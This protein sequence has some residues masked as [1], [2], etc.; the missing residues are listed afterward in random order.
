MIWPDG[1]KEEEDDLSWLGTLNLIAGSLSPQL[2]CLRITR[3][4]TQEEAYAVAISAPLYPLAYLTKITRIVLREHGPLLGT[5][6]RLLPPPSIAA[7]LLETDHSTQ[8]LGVDFTWRGDAFT[9]NFAIHARLVDDHEAARALDHSSAWNQRAV[10]TL[11]LCGEFDNTILRSPSAV[12]AY[13]RP[14]DPKVTSLSRS[15]V[16]TGPNRRFISLSPVKV[17][18]QTL[19]RRE[20][21]PPLVPGVA[22][23]RPP[24]LLQLR[25]AQMSATVS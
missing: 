12:E 25:Q 16:K 3:P 8:D 22:G 14:R 13:V 6:I 10:V 5:F 7:R 24:S 11:N 1:H 17:T 15:V 2:V 19:L 9:V 18:I 23:I 20:S 4:F 21:L